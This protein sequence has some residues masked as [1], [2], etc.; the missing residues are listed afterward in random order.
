MSMSMFNS[1]IFNVFIKNKLILFK[2]LFVCLSLAFFAIPLKTLFCVALEALGIL[3]LGRFVRSW[4][5]VILWLCLLVLHIAQLLNLVITGK[6]IETLTL[7]NLYSTSDIGGRN[8]IFLL[9][10]GAVYLFVYLFKFSQDK[11]SPKQGWSVLIV[12]LVAELLEKDVLPINAAIC[13][14]QDAYSQAFFVPEYNDGKEFERKTVFDDKDNLWK[15]TLM[16]GNN[17]VLIFTEGM[18]SVVLSEKLTPNAYRLSKSG[19]NVKNY[20]N[21][22]AATYRGIKGQLMSGFL[23]VDG[24]AYSFPH[25]TQL[26]AKH[27]KNRPETLESILRDRG[28]STVFVSPHKKT[29]YFND[30]IK[31]IGFQEVVS[32]EENLSDKKLYANLTREFNKLAEKKK[33]FFLV[34][35]VL[36]S[37]LGLD[38]PDLKYG[39][40]TNV[41]LNKFYNQ[42]FWFG[43]F[44][45]EFEKSP[46]AENTILV[47]T[48]D[49]AS[50]PAS[51]FR[52]TFDSKSKLFADEIPLIV[53]KKG[54]EPQIFDAKGVNS[55]ALAPTILNILGGSK[56]QNHF[57][58]S[59]LFDKAERKPYEYMYVEGTNCHSLVN[60]SYVKNRFDKD[61]LI[62]KKYYDYAG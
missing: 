56:A 25:I 59:S 39:D 49:H 11:L 58:G 27:K 10:L 35:Y 42:D 61:C 18:S 51:D 60:G 38:S 8:I 47:F 13:T 9:F 48:T 31:N 4:Y 2:L 54:M 20:Y 41:Y 6:Y 28:Y 19:F 44:W 22:T 1:V 36:G 57:L 12:F 32:E 16:R 5:W 46:A 33:P 52:N 40:G 55:L 53:Y 29:H 24:G 3:F 45:E 26:Y 23:C 7:L 30:F 21:H 17:V 15:N 43:K 14:I 62:A 34:T 50:Y 37:H